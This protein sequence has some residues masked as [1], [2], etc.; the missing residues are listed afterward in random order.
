MTD[1]LLI[2]IVLGLGLWNLNLHAA[3]QGLKR[4]LELQAL[5]IDQLYAQ[6]YDGSYQSTTGCLD[7]FLW[8]GV[9]GLIGLIVIGASL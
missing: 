8:L 7:T 4:Q 2:L 3:N 1:W 6:V 5:Q 9:V